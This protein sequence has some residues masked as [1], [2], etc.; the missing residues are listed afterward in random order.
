MTERLIAE[1]MRI[2][3]HFDMDDKS[4]YEKN[5]L[6]FIYDMLDG[7]DFPNYDYIMDRIEIWL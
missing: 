5:V 4:S 3:D 7:E 1:A 2:C 6:E